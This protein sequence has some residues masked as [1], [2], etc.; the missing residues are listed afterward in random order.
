MHKILQKIYF[1][2]HSGD[3]DDDIETLGYEESPDV[4]EHCIKQWM[5]PS[6]PLVFPSKSINV[7]VIY[8]RLLEQ[9]FKQSH[10]L[11]LSD[12]DLLYGT[13]RFFQPYPSFQVEYDAMLELITTETIASSTNPSVL[14]TVAYF[15]DEFM[16]NSVEYAMLTKSL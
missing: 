6:A 5:D 4:L 8:A 9:H 16:V 7:A 1:A 2:L 13:D 12:P 3:F 14:K 10:L 11:Y 15:N